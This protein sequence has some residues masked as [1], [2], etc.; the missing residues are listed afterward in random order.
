M[1]NGFDAIAKGQHIEQTG[2][3]PQLLP[4]GSVCMEMNPKK[5]SQQLA[6][7]VAM[8]EKASGMLGS[9]NGQEKFLSLGTSHFVM[10]CRA[11]QQHATAPDGS[12]LQPLPEYLPLLQ[13]GWKWTILS[14]QIEDEFPTFTSSRQATL[15]SVNSAAKM[16]GEVESML[17]IAAY[18]EA[19]STLQAAVDMV[20]STAPA[21]ASYLQQVADFAR[22]FLGGTGFPLLKQLKDY[23][24]QVASIVSSGQ[25]GWYCD[26]LQLTCALASPGFKPYFPSPHIS[27]VQPVA[28]GPGLKFGPTILVGEDNMALL[29]YHDFRVSVQGDQMLFTRL[30]LLTTMLTTTKVSD[31]VSKLIVKSDFDKMTRSLQKQAVQMERILREAWRQEDHHVTPERK[32]SA[33][34]KLSV[35]MCLLL[36]GKQKFGRDPVLDSFE[37]ITKMYG[38]DLAGTKPEALSSSTT[39]KPKCQPVRDLLNASAQEVAL[40]QNSH[41]HLDGRHLCWKQFCS[42]S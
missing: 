36:L 9:V 6:A 34:G 1:V 35:R 26:C 38:E 18:L 13:E 12:K 30:A 27:S 42:R 40:L 33:F 8:C 15:N 32:A 31:G 17:Q 3:K 29:A 14:Y 11:L 37:E 21:C 2:L 23:C 39:A 19:G 5:R 4:L 20:K 25:T 22:Q 10:Y 7:N 16:V 24:C 41:L 28:V